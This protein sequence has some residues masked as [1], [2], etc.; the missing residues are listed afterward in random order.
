MYFNEDCVKE[1]EA[2]EEKNFGKS[3]F[4]TEDYEDSQCT[5]IKSKKERLDSIPDDYLDG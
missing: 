1:P 3:W 5:E 2:F 4:Y